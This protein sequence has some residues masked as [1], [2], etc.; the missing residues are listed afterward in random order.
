M[1]G[2]NRKLGARW[3]LWVALAIMVAAALGARYRQMAWP[4]SGRLIATLPAIPRDRPSI[5]DAASARLFSDARERLESEPF[6]PDA[7]GKMGMLLHAYGMLEGAEACYRR[8]TALQP[9]C[10]D[11]WYYL[12]R[13]LA[14][15]GRMDEAISV[16]QTAVDG[17]SDYL[18]GLL[19][20]AELY[21][22][23]NQTSN[24][25]RLYQIALERDD[26]CEAAYWGLGCIASLEGDEVG[27]R[28]N[29]QS[30]LQLRPDFGEAR[31]ALAMAERDGPAAVP[32]RFA[33]RIH[34]AASKNAV[35]DPLMD[36]IF[37]LRSDAR[38][39][40]VTGLRL[41]R[42]G[43]FGE[44]VP[45]LQR[46]VACRPDDAQLLFKLA[47]SL[48]EIG[49]F[50]RAIAAYE[51]AAALAPTHAGVPASLADLH[52]RLGRVDEAIRLWRESLR[53]DAENRE[54]RQKLAHALQ[55]EGREREIPREVTMGMKNLD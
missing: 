15:R 4:F 18:P 25:R 19:A 6:D 53:L 21:M 35:A 41:H 10:Y 39:D 47:Q 34:G 36:A 26:T 12:G 38:A 23:V 52:N 17:N 20:L 51:R 16:L 3:Y 1:K 46:A 5:A 49:E 37:A 14:T 32:D 24:G 42:V 8:A 45:H 9:S 28:R 11:W 40:V 30:A 55:E 29:L 44:A 33:R 27:A 43:R 31:Y 2:A 22:S 48:E 50:D 54:V 7:N 13:C